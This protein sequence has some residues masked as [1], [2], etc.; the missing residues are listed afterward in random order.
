MR[1]SRAEGILHE[2]DPYNW[3]FDADGQFQY[4][5]QSSLSK[6]LN[7][8]LDITVHALSQRERVMLVDVL[9]R[10]GALAAIVR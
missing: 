9:V 5:R 4:T 3:M 2:H 1:S 10:S 8:T 7:E 6:L